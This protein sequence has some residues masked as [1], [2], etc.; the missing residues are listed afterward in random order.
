MDEK[1]IQTFDIPLGNWEWFETKFKKTI[2][3]AKKCGSEIPSFEIKREYE[4]IYNKGQ[5]NEKRVDFKEVVVIGMRPQIAGWEFIG[6]IEHFE[7]GNLVRTVPNFDGGLEKYHTGSQFCDHC[8]TN[9]KRKNTYIVR[10]GENEIL[11]VGKSCLKDFTGHVSPEYYARLAEF[12]HELEVRYNEAGNGFR[13]EDAMP[14]KSFLKIAHRIVKLDEG[15]RTAAIHSGQATSHQ[16]SWYFHGSNGKNDTAWTD[17][18]RNVD[19]F[20]V[21]TESEIIDTVINHHK[22]MDAKGD[23]QNNLKVLA[24][25]GYVRHKD[26]GIVCYMLQNYFNFEKKKAEWQLKNEANALKTNEWIGEVR[27]KKKDRRDFEVTYVGTQGFNH[28]YGTTYFHRF[29]DCDGRLIVAKVSKSLTELVSELLGYENYENGS[30]QEGDKFEFKGSITKHDEFRD[31]K[32][33]LVNR[34]KLSKYE[35]ING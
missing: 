9:R 27:E 8:K 34:L 25:E 28:E 23:F 6:T 16:T 19:N 24:N 5:E 15:Y 29:E 11:Q 3:S 14:L 13:I 2:N 31:R 4:K 22:E 35:A 20:E 33:T 18:R 1:E 17:F 12:I 10:N 30:L 32:Q 21:E 7:S 26:Y